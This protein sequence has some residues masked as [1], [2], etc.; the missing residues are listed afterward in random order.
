MFA[1]NGFVGEVIAG[2]VAQRRQRRRHGR[3][4]LVQVSDSGGRPRSG[5]QRQMRRH[6]VADDAHALAGEETH[7]ESALAPPPD[8]FL[9][10]RHVDH[11]DHIPHLS[12]QYN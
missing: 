11:R 7:V 1:E 3:A 4:L 2:I 12:Q 5:R 8:A 6:F 10:R 9:R